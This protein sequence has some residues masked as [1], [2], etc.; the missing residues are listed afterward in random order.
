MDVV[1]N[2]QQRQA[3]EEAKAGKNLFI[4]GGAG[5]GKS[6]VLR[7]IA[8]ERQH[9]VKTFFFAHLRPPQPS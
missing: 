2:T 8:G 1:L 7:E 3:L 9:L 6:V 4:T 5:T